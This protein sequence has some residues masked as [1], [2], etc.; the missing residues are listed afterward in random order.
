VL[1]LCKPYEPGMPVLN[2]KQIQEEISKINGWEYDN[3]KNHIYR[4]YEFSGYL[5][6][7]AFIN[8]IAWFAHKQQHHPDINITYNSA[9]VAYQTHEAKGITQNDLICATQINEL[10]TE[11]TSRQI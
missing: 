2:K 3:N 6:N 10:Y 1:I 11:N 4:K 7:I 5:K 8:A 9:T